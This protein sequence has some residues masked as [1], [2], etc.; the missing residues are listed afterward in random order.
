MKAKVLVP[1]LIAVV[2]VVA[3][4]VGAQ[5]RSA[6]ETVEE[7][8]LS[9]PPPEPEP[10]P[11][12]EPP[13]EPA[14]PARAARTRTP[15]RS[16]TPAS[17]PAVRSPEPVSAP[18]RPPEPPRRAQPPPPRPPALVSVRVAEGTKIVFAL[19][20]ALSTKTHRAGDTFSGVVSQPVQIG[21]RVIIPEGSVVRG[22]VAR[23]KRAGRI[24]GRAEMDLRLEQLE[25]PDGQVFD[26]VATL[27]ELDESEKETLGEEGEIV[28]QGS[29][30]RDVATIGGGAGIGAAIG[31]I[32]GGGGK[33]AATGAGVGAA[34]GTAAVL[35]TRGRDIKLE[36]G[37]E[38]AL[39]LDRAITVKVRR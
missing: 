3:F 38:L 31:A 19:D 34:A 6:P 9:E 7:V 33:G 2:A 8:A 20:E 13:A 36:R 30:K 29:K 22:T 24:R 35:L 16:A 32:A 39:Q 27:T 17:S 25:L 10:P 18:A 37:S 26:L 21:G 23:S 28:G 4:F 15:R 14:R 11:A 5:F 1:V 12:A